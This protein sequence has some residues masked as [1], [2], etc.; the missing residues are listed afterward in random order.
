MKLKNKDSTKI[1]DLST[2]LIMTAVLII[3]VLTVIV[4]GAI[5]WKKSQKQGKKNDNLQERTQLNATTSE[6]NIEPTRVDIESS[7]E[8]SNVPTL[9]YLDICSDGQDKKFN[10]QDDVKNQVKDLPDNSTREIPESAF[11]VGELIGEGN[12]GK[13]YKGELIGLYQ[14]TNSK[15]TVAIKSIT[16]VARKQEID[17]FLVEIKIMSQVDPHMNLVNMIGACTSDLQNNGKM[18]LLLEFCPYGD[19]KTYLTKNK[20]NILSGSSSNPINSRCLLKWAYDI[21]NG[22]KFLA[23]NQIMHGDLAARNVLMDE[24]LLQ[25]GCPRAL[26]ADFGLSKRFYDNVA[27]EKESR[28]FVPWKWMALEYLTRD[29]FTL[30]SDV[31]SFGVLFWELLSFGRTPY[32]HQGYDEVVEKL[33]NG[34]RLELPEE[35][36]TITSWSPKD[37]F[38]EMSNACFEADTLKRAP[39]SKLVGMIQYRLSSD[40]VIHYKQTKEIYHSTRANN[41]L[42][43]VGHQPI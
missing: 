22:M 5:I 21:A 4:T 6:A 23:E 1:K 14:P 38:L 32:G 9:N 2:Q 27:Y 7:I 24:D 11:E 20:S 3:I 13:V 15:T 36:D 18:W 43:Y 29:I 35:V 16:G 10:S 41:Y 8:P 12:F 33:K 31:W 25:G 34:Y 30:N 37:L 19:I 40:E 17:D 42:G 39:F 26:V 28:V